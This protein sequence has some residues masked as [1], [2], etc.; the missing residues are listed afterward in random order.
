[1]PYKNQKFLDIKNENKNVYINAFWT[2]REKK[3]RN[4]N[5]KTN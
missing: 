2:I 1:M 4:N 5:N 3:T